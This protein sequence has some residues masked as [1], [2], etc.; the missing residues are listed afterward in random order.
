M[1][2]AG[3]AMLALA[4]VSS[5]VASDKQRLL[6]QRIGPSVSSVYL[7][8]A[9]GTGER[10]LPGPSALDY[11]PALSP[12]G[13]WIAFTSERRG[14]AD[15]YRVRVDGS[16][17]ERLTSDPAYDD[18]AS[19]SPDG[20]SLAFVSTRT[21]GT[22][23]IWTLD[24]ATKAAR[25]L[26]ATAGG[27]FRPSW[28][29]DGKWIAFSSDRGTRIESNPPEWE[30]LHRT[31]IYLIARNGQ[32]LRRLTDG[33]RSAGSPRWSSDG[34]RIVFY[35]LEVADTHDAREDDQQSRVVSQIVSVDT[36][37]GVR[38]EH[39]FGAGLK[40]SPQFLDGDRVGYL[41]KAGANPGIV[42]TSGGRGTSGDI[43]NPSFSRDGRTVVYDRGRV[44]TERVSYDLLQPLY[45]KNTA[46]ELVHLGRLG[47]YS[48]DGRRLAF[49]EPAGNAEWAI[50]VM[51]SDGT[52]RKTVFFEQGTAALSP[53]WSYDG[54]RLVFGLGGGFDTR[55][56]PSR[57][58]VTHADGSNVRV[59]ATGAGAG[60]PSFSPD[61]KRL[62]FRVWGKDANERG[63]RILALDTAAITHLTRDE[64]DTFPGWSPK[65]DLIAF[66]SW[67]NGDFDIY[68]IRPDGS[69]LKRLTTAPGND[70]HSSWSPD[71][72]YL[73]FSSS[74]LGF[75]DEAPLFDDQ[76][77][78]YG[79]VF[80]MRSD[81]SDQYPLTDNQWEDGAGSW[82]PPVGNT[83]LH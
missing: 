69:G 61:G 14:S 65:G 74:R 20:S 43:R 32:G 57:V 10:R 53:R 49:S 48:P 45:S 83:R 51:D 33:T 47:A 18:Q 63:L 16:S 56:A 26:T 24:L 62:V 3:A 19:W 42:Y 67:R 66:T 35:E 44:S 31:S 64:F 34:K 73:I 37:T 38:R 25:N 52:Q 8:N 5:T 9:D 13:Q 82:R 50:V 81:G 21:S 58:I 1:R 30:H 17:L 22:A 41:V 75:K 60:F 68:T 40:V 11:N 6:I 72:R 77:Q 39:T 12:D 36:E 27:D 46:F 80:V 59:L 54:R 23:D 29:P 71:G 2:I 76:P 4:I 70:A 55:N 15:L 28:S 78:P 7:A 79:E